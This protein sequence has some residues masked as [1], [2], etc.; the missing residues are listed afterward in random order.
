[1]DHKAVSQKAVGVGYVYRIVCSG[2]DHRRTQKEVIKY[3][4]SVAKVFN[5][6]VL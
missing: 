2:N 3:E 6:S 5:T 4:T 1:M